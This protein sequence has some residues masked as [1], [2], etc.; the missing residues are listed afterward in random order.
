MKL[1]TRERY[2]LR[3]MMS[4]ATLSSGE[5]PVGLRQVSKHSGISRRYLEQLVSPLKRAALLQA[6]AGRDGGYVLA[7]E[8]EEIKLSDIFTAAIGQIAV[9][10]CAVGEETCNNGEFCNCKALWAL[11]NH[12]ITKTLDE[13][14]LAD[15]LREDWRSV[16]EGKMEQSRAVLNATAP[17]NR[18]SL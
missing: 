17:I 14:S 4:I 11:L 6:T 8:P 7:K 12:K 13:H 10:D 9:T 16:V 15:L 18:A 1:R 2:S 3:M 5:K